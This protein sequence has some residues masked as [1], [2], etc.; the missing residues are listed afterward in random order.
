MSENYIPLNLSSYAKKKLGQFLL[1]LEENWL[2]EI[3]YLLSSAW[4]EDKNIPP[5]QAHITSG[6]MCLTTVA[7]M[8]T[9][10]YK[11]DEYGRGKAG[12]HFK[13]L[14][15]NHYPWNLDKPLGISSTDAVDQLY[16]EIRNPLA[17]S[18]GIDTS[19]KKL[20]YL[21]PA[22][23]T[24]QDLNKR[25]ADKQLPFGS[26]SIKKNNNEITFAP[27]SFYW[28]IR[29]MIENILSTDKDVDDLFKRLQTKYGLTVP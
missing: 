24:R 7:G 14:L 18:L 3:H 28:G 29:K 25:I 23:Y 21:L 9:I 19:S 15:N 1:L 13:G 12:I 4:T 17:H 5:R 6:V 26:P 8:S 2:K 11:P 22:V 16:N 10:F 20:I 27:A